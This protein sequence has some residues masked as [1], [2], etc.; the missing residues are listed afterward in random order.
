MISRKYIAESEILGRNFHLD[1]FKTKARPSFLVIMFGGSG[2][3]EQEYRRR[4]QTSAHVFGPKLLELEQ[5]FSFAFTYVT[6]PYDIPF[7]DFSRQ[8]DEAARWKKHV[9][10]DILPLWPD[11]P[12]YFIGYS[13]GFALAVQGLQ[14]DR[15][16]FGGSALGGDCISDGLEENCSRLE[17]IALYYNKEDRVYSS[18]RQA[19]S[20]LEEAGLAR[21]FRKL[22]GGHDL[23]DYI[24]NDS[25]SGLVRRAAHLQ[26]SAGQSRQ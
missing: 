17:P 14:G 16:C 10:S 25:F 15:L 24:N 21:C 2:I 26:R 19:I 1:L 22:P 12:H 18:N 9:S 4:L 5:E 23:D 8:E 6:A 13:G 20:E 7:N 3:S 11:L